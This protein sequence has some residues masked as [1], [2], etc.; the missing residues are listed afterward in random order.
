MMQSTMSWLL[1]EGCTTTKSKRLFKQETI[2]S[3]FFV[4]LFFPLLGLK[5][6]R[7]FISLLYTFSTNKV[8]KTD[9]DKIFEHKKKKQ[10]KLNKKNVKKI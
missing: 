10:A 7:H 6:K 8:K 3:S 4:I 5:I 1:A 2:L 9:K